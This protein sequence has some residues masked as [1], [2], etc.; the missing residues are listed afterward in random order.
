MKQSPKI[1]IPFWHAIWPRILGMSIMIIVSVSIFFFN[2]IVYQFEN[3]S[4]IQLQH[5]AL[6]ISDA[7]KA[8]FKS[9]VMV[10]GFENIQAYI[11]RLITTRAKNDIEI[12]IMLLK[13]DKSAIVAS[14]N[15][16][17]IGFTSEREHKDLLAALMQKNP[18]IV[19][20]Q[21]N[22]SEYEDPDDQQ[23]EDEGNG[24]MADDPADDP[25]H[26]DYYLSD[27][28][29]RLS[30]TTPLFN[31][32]Q[33]LGSI[34]IMMS[35][36]FLDEKIEKVYIA[37]FIA[38]ILEVLIMLLCM[39]FFLNKNLLKP[40]WQMVDNIIEIGSVNLDR[41]TGLSDRRDEFGI[42]AREF[43][44]MLIRI[45]SLIREMREMVD[46]IA[47]D[48]KSPITRIRGAAEV[49][50][51]SDASVDN[52]KEMAVNTIEECDN[53]L[54]II[55]TML[56]ISEAE[57]GVAR[58]DSQVVDFSET[59]QKAT[60]L[61]QVLAEERDIKLQT[62]IR[63]DCQIQGNVAMIQRMIANL[64]DNALKY[65]YPKGQIEIKVEK[66]EAHEQIVLSI[67]DTGVGISQKDL[68]KIFNR[69]YRCDPSRSK[70]GIGLGLSLCQS[71]AK[72]HN[73]NITAE[74]ELKKGSTFVITLPC[75]S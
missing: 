59:V 8:E 70:P 52:Y 51:M 65:S 15:P 54:M 5:E 47:H 35:L 40:L 50:L 41:R 7:L 16:D 56:F 63:P 73:G 2:Y 25:T 44:H 68:P 6:L 21:D 13:G 43:N 33:P 74:S 22:D 26:P 18:I 61:F 36:R 75:L 71:I 10:A 17:N 24:S 53:M 69:F 64:I 39:T 3:L 42:L 38:I 55:N 58:I 57:S 1:K 60:Y 29:R 11:D 34:N 46:N 66:Q 20:G 28:H 48:L 23:R 49:T 30:I 37:I 4:K 31:G 12:N 67:S 14:N 45:Q 19:I 62:N 72:L 27:E 9:Q 32:D